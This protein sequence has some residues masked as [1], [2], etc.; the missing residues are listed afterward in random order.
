MP[1]TE[2]NSKQ[3][4]R[5]IVCQK[6]SFQ[7]VKFIFV[8][9]SVSQR[10]HESCQ[11]LA[12]CLVFCCFFH[13]KKNIQLKPLLCFNLQ[14]LY[15]DLS[16]RWFYFFFQWDWFLKIIMDGQQQ[17]PLNTYLFECVSIQ[18]SSHSFFCISTN[19]K[20]TKIYNITSHVNALYHK[21]TVHT[22]MFTNTKYNANPSWIKTK[23]H[24]LLL[25]LFL[26]CECLTLL[27]NCLALGETKRKKKK[28]TTTE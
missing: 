19:K 16:T 20:K 23:F 15:F 24:F 25:L 3:E 17:G 4:Q 18:M 26:L 8:H 6:W 9:W 13:K 22:Q 10:W 14:N 2:K 7:K 11:I 27:Q 21:F 28:Q 5:D 1:S 12:D